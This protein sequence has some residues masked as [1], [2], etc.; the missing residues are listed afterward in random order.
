M[1]HESDMTD[2]TPITDAALD[3]AGVR[4]RAALPA[5]DFAPG[6]ADR[7]MARLAA[8]RA[9]VPPAM[10]R[11]VAIQRNFRM[12]AA[13]AAV[14]ILALGLHNTYVARAD[15]TSL[16]EAAIGLSPVSAESI[17]SA[18]SDAFQ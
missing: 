13:A 16:M 9:T 6:F 8:A 7:T 14:A 17:L 4:L 2:E 1:I 12:L 18:S 11:V 10:P 15:N 3:R 5:A